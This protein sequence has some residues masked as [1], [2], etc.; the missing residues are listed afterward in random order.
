[1]RLANQGRRFPDTI[2]RRRQAAGHYDAHGEW[3]PGTV[4][5]VELRA[6]VQPL[7]TE[8]AELVG[9][10]S[11]PTGAPSMSR[12]PMPWWRRSTTARPTLC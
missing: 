3:V 1:M 12:S 11:Y 8:D 5:D 4:V 10:R 2:T 9:G 7:G 6:S